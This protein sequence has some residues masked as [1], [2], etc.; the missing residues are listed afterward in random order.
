MS[1]LPRLY[2][3]QPPETSDRFVEL[4]VQCRDIK[5]NKPLI[6]EDIFLLMAELKRKVGLKYSLI[7]FRKQTLALLG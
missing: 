1:A 6:M 2:C 5:F 4:S 3:F 7:G